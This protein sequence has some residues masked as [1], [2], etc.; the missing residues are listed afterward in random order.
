MEEPTGSSWYLLRTARFAPLFATQ[1]LGAFNDNLFRTGLSLWIVFELA[2]VNT[3]LLVNV[4]AGLFILPFF[5]LSTAAGQIADKVDKAGLIRKVKV[6]EI[7]I[8]AGGATAWLLGNA[9]MLFAILLAMG[10]Q[11]A[12]FGPSKYS[13]LPQHLEE[14]ELVGGNALIEMGTF[15]AILLGTILGGII[16]GSDAPWLLA[17]SLLVVAVLGYL[18]SRGIP[19]APAPVP[20][21]KI[22]W[23]PLTQLREMFGFTRREHYNVLLSI[24]GISWF[25]LMGS[26][27]LTQIPNYVAFDLNGD[28]GVVT[29]LLASFSVGI[30]LGAVL[31]ARLSG[32]RVEIGV[33]PFGALGLSVFALH[34]STLSMPLAEDRYGLVEFVQLGGW[35]VVLDV[36]LLSVFGALFIV[37]LNAFVQN[38][39]P[40]EKRARII[41]L[42]NILN[43]FFMIIAAVAG[44]VLLTVVGLSIP[45]LFLT[46][47]LMNIAV[48]LFIFQQ[49]PL[50]AAR[51][52]V[53][54]L[55]HTM[56]RVRHEGLGNIP[57]EGPALI[58]C[59]H[60][61]YVDALILAGAV[62]RPIRFVMVKTIY[63]IPV[64]NFVFRVGKTI[65][66][67]SKSADAD[68]YERAFDEIDEALAAG[69]LLCIFPEGSLTLDGEMG[70]FKAGIQKIIARRA[71]P[72]IPMALRG[73]WGS[74]FSASHGGFFKHPFRRIHSRIDVVA[75]PP[76]SPDGLEVG[77]LR[78]HIL[79]LRGD[80]A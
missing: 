32:R 62:R 29:L 8:M 34:L 73:L 45:Q 49:V 36:V 53:W 27:Y 79:G 71:V 69:D 25:W 57:D 38:S 4:A 64:L 63:D 11:S 51:F 24:L 9:W 77:G 66:I 7:L 52:L 37:P 74:F 54:V 72:V 16:A 14:P 46:L 80:R 31:C 12:F 47:A 76:W 65:P 55:G 26:V 44:A 58:A 48:S 17:P 15:L 43:A 35:K 21:L 59:N 42:N 39:A 3:N 60:V 78:E 28:S 10:S 6:A 68:A 56:Y 1:F 33:V 70:E 50:F 75:D 2:D 41:A 23:N 13:I 5:L 20:E 61:S 22:N 19:A 40:K 18:T 67:I 30:G